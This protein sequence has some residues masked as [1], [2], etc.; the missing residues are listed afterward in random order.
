MKTQIAAV[1]AKVADKPPV[2]V[3]TYVSG[4]G[5]LQILGG[6]QIDGYIIDLAGGKSIFPEAGFDPIS[7][8]KAAK[9]DIDAFVITPEVTPSEGNENRTS[10]SRSSSTPMPSRRWISAA[11][12]R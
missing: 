11:G 5:P 12:P 8:E 3:L 4:T 7:L 1:Q 9:L 10:A 6:K 2:E